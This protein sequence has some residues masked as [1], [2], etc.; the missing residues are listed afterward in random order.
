MKQNTYWLPLTK[1]QVAM[2]HRILQDNHNSEQPE[3][4]LLLGQ[5][6]TESNPITGDAPGSMWI[7]YYTNAEGKAMAAAVRKALTQL[8]EA[9]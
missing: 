6:L 4:G 9:A 1:K 2:I 5:P 3:P 7:R 8:H